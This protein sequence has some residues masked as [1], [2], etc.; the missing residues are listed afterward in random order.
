M[1]LEREL[2]EG[3]ETS[4][5]RVQLRL[6]NLPACK[7]QLLASKLKISLQGSPIELLSRLT[8]FIDYKIGLMRRVVDISQDQTVEE[9]P[10]PS[11][12]LILILHLPH[13]PFLFPPPPPTLP[14]S[15]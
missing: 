3:T 8:E 1:D 12:L 15:L 11:P 7:L 14:Q 6:V 4:V 10:S 2:E 9:S 5:Q 13:Q